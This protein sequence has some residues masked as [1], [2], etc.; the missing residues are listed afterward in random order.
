[1]AGQLEDPAPT[2]TIIPKTPNPVD[3]SE[4]RNISCTTMFSKVLEGQVLVKLRGELEPN[5]AQYGGIPK[6][7][8]EHMLFELWENVLAG[9]EGGKAAAAVLGVDYKKAFNRMEHA[10]CIDQLRLLGASPGSLSVR[11]FLEDRTMRITID[12]QTSEPATIQR[13]SPQGRV[14]GC[15]LYCATTQRLTRDLRTII[16]IIY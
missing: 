10:V 14:L 11:V 4:C 5:T 9:M 13:G 2:V 3:L 12:G 1:M 8:V 6:C 7:G 16:I 15:L